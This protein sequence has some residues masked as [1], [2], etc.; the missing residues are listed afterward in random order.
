MQLPW[1]IWWP[2]WGVLFLAQVALGLHLRIADD[3]SVAAAVGAGVVSLL[4]HGWTFFGLYRMRDRMW[5]KGIAVWLIGGVVISALAASLYQADKQQAAVALGGFYWM[6]TSYF[7]GMWLLRLACVPGRPIV[8]V[9]RT[10]LDE[11]L[12]MRIG[13]IFAM[14]LVL[15]LPVLPLLL[16]GETKLQYRV[17]NLLTYSLVGVNLILGLMTILL[18]CWTITREVEKKQI[19]LTMTKPI[20]RFEYLAGKW[21]GVMLVNL[22]LLAVAGG[23]IAVFARVMQ[24]GGA[25]DGLDRTRVDDEILVSR[26]AIRPDPPADSEDLFK[27]HL[28]RLQREHPDT[29]GEPESPVSADVAEEVWGQVMAEWHTLHPM[30]LDALRD[31]VRQGRQLT[32]EEISQYSAQAVPRTFVFSGL[33]N[34][35]DYGDTVQIVLNFKTGATP[36]R[37]KV[38]LEMSYDGVRF[39]TMQPLVP[40]T[41][42]PLPINVDMIDADGNLTL[43]FRNRH[44]DQPYNVEFTPGEGMELFYT[45]GT[46]EGNLIRSLFI[47]F[48]CLG[49][50]AMLGLATGTFLGFAVSAL[51]TASVAIIGTMS[52][53]ISDSLGNFASLGKRDAS[54]WELISGAFSKLGSHLGDGELFESFKMIVRMFGQLVLAFIP[55]FGKYSHVQM[56]AEGRLLHMGILFDATF[57][58][59]IVWTGSALLAGWLI[60]RKRELAKITV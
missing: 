9:A 52:G 49:L 46:F 47:S 20:G 14:L 5:A 11:A 32:D 17:Q 36:R 31:S 16:S 27:E 33:Q 25:Q 56:V 59:G 40:D 6:A 42:Y 4:W 39:G 10:V 28:L 60:W 12:R 3:P 37:G 8:G 57:W 21:L 34:A 51:L 23:G 30:N 38:I 15:L 50:L 55:A 26:I 45:V 2:I 13:L 44:F 1:V 18:G 54:G 41:P 58:I 24:K 7:V 22:L 53:Y 43:T 19:F 48:L 29:F 35:A